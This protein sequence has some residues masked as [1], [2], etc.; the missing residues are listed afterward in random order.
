MFLDAYALLAGAAAAFSAALVFQRSMYAAAIC[1][2]GVLVQVAGLFFLLGSQLLGLTQILVYAGAVMVMIVIAVM[3]APA[4][5]TRRWAPL[6]APSWLKT[7]VLAV[8][9]IELALI[10]RMPPSGPRVTAPLPKA[11]ET[12]MAA[13]LFGPYALMTEAIGLLILVSALAVLNLPAKETR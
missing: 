4:R 8:P 3:A 12:E 2:L 5:L 13:V 11:F 6:A 9:L 10:A 7:A 1:L